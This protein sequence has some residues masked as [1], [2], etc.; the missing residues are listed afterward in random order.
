MKMR[1]KAVPVDPKDKNSS[2]PVAE[3]IHARVSLESD[4]SVEKV[5]WFRPVMHLSFEHF[6]RI[7]EAPGFG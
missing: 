4:R 6:I 1:H 5:F 3:R 7:I 2:L